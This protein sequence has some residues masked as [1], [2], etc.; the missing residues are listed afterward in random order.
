MHL[1]KVLEDGCGSHNRLSQEERVQKWEMISSQLGS[2]MIYAGYLVY[3]LLYL[4]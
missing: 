3:R 4:S 1:P 2:H